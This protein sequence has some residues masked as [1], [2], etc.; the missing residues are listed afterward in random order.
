MDEY[1]DLPYDNSDFEEIEGTV[2]VITFRNDQNGYT[3]L[4]LNTDYE[5]MTVVGNF[6]YVSAGDMLRLRGKF[7]THKIYGQQFHAESSEQIRP[8]TAEAILKYLSAGAIKGIGPSTA[9]K[10]VERFGENTLDI[11][12]N[13]PERLS[14]IRGISLAKAVKIGSEYKK[15]FGMRDVML[16]FVSMGISTEESL[17]IYK[18]LGASCVEKITENPYKLCSDDIGFSFDRA[19]SIASGLGISS[20]NKYRVESGMLYVLHH[21]LS[22]GHTCLPRDKVVNITAQ[23]LSVSPDSTDIACDSLCEDGRISKFNIND[24]EFVALDY[25]YAAECYIAGRLRTM[26]EYPPVPITALKSQ[27]NAIELVSG[28]KYEE[29]QKEAIMAALSKG[30]LILTGGPGTGKTT[31][32]KAIITILEQQGLEFA[33]AAPTGRAAQRMSDLT[34]YEA[35]TIHRLLEAER[36]QDGK[37]YFSKN[38]KNPLP[39]QAIILDELSMVDTLLF[40]ALLRA[41]RLGCRII[42]VGDRNQLPAVGAGNVLGDLIESGELPVVC[43]DT[44]FRQAMQSKIVTNAHLVVSGGN[45]EY[46]KKEGDFF[47]VKE[48]NP[49]RA[50]KIINDLCTERLPKAYGFDP[51]S[52]IQVLCPSRKGETGTG[53]LNPLL[54]SR[55]N[56]SEFGKAEFKNKHAVLREG[57]KVMQIRNNY[58]VVW[59]RND[60]KQGCGVFNGDIG[61]LQSVDRLTGILS[62]RFDDK[63][64]LYSAD[65]A[66]DLEQAYSITIHKSQ[67]SEYNCVVIPVV[68][69]PP[70]LMFRNLLY[71]GIT[72]AKKL[73]VL[74]G[75]EASVEKM[76]ANNRKTLRY[77]ALKTLMLNDE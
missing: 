50:A 48:S 7:E 47:L 56:P 42:M 54:A 32:L 23:L 24:T 38:E 63:I 29:R 43:L 46:S 57:D 8:A 37:L 49:A 74:V 13:E 76:I 67:G 22:N 19:D 4:Q 71:T 6:S 39:A 30:L 52:D 70:Q 51:L 12:E 34:G 18:N 66:D 68:G 17:R 53:S 35:K 15:M 58:D 73:L 16:R 21:N 45:P 64:A 40:E 25:I 44:I 14:Q 60:G 31:T 59:T 9:S 5:L 36:G 69:A 61:I 65:D 10:I 28:I 72:R 33:L 41:A 55:L 20:D 27:I 62:V 3:V 26:L 1:F 2:E 77:T 11:M 75:N